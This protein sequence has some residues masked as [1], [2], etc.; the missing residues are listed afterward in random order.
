MY[1]AHLY[2]RMQHLTLSHL[3]EKN[4][5]SRYNSTKCTICVVF[6][7]LMSLAASPLQLGM[8]Y[9]T[10]LLCRYFTLGKAFATRQSLC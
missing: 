8:H 1:D 7:Q 10:S 6:L 4:D 9:W 5:F 2:Y 3:Q